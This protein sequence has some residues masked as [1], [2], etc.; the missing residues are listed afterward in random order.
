MITHLQTRKIQN[1]VTYNSTIFNSIF[2][3]LGGCRAHLRKE[4]CGY[5]Q[6]APWDSSPRNPGRESS[7]LQLPA[8]SMGDLS[9]AVFLPLKWG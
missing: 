5:P 7:V 4:P 9:V 8:G 6:G 3:V 1:K 2:R